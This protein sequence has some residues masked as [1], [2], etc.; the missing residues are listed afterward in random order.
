MPLHTISRVH[1]LL[2]RIP[3]LIRRFPANQGL[4]SAPSASSAAACV[5]S[6]SGKRRE[7][8]IELKPIRSAPQLDRHR[9]QLRVE[10]LEHQLAHRLGTLCAD[11]LK[12]CVE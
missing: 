8:D 2:P 11:T 9:A 1:L 6:T 4:R 5:C 10:H 7:L 3:N 12:L